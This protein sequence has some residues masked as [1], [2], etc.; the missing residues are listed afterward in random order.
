[1]EKLNKLTN[2]GKARRMEDLAKPFQRRAENYRVR[3]EACEKAGQS[4]QAKLEHD[5][6][7][8]AE[9][10]AALLREAAQLMRERDKQPEPIPWCFDDTGGLTAKHRGYRVRVL[11]SQ[12]GSSSYMVDVFQFGSCVH[13]GYHDTLDAAKSAAIQWVDQREGE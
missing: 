12:R 7:D 8:I 5:I 1:M 4:D 10:D 6:A 3:A 11:P 13:S 2:E 9:S